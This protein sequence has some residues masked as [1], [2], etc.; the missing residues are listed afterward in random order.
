M[1]YTSSGEKRRPE[2]LALDHREQSQEDV[3]QGACGLAYT[4]HF[5]GNASVDISPRST[6]VG[7]PIYSRERLKGNGGPVKKVRRYVSSLPVG[8]C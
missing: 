6:G 2:I 3:K 7:Y 4:L 1:E 8:S 5:K